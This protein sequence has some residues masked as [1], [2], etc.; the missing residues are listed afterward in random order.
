M[1]SGSL[2]FLIQ[3]IENPDLL[4][5]IIYGEF[6]EYYTPAEATPAVREWVLSYLAG[7]LEV[8]DYCLQHVKAEAH[9]KFLL[10]KRGQLAGHHKEWMT[11]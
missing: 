2:P 3:N 8:A 7:G 10:E 6:G 1:T 4:S 11:T 9:R 5:E